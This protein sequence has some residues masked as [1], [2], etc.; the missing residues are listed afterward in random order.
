M[1]LLL[2]NGRGAWYLASNVV[3]E[4]SEESRDGAFD[5]YRGRQ[6]GETPLV[7]GVCRVAGAGCARAAGGLEQYLDDAEGAARATAGE[8]AP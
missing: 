4:L 7:Q 3:R 6:G 1:G 5:P 8:D 2:E